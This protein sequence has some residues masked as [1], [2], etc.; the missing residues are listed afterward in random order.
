[1]SKSIK[2]PKKEALISYGIQ[3][4]SNKYKAISSLHQNNK[5]RGI[6]AKRNYWAI[7]E[8]S[9]IGSDC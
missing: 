3:P 8:K 1:M 5:K 6:N 9:P 4:I 7:Y 2:D